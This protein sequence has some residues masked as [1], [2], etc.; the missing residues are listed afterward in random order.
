MKS[1]SI[2]GNRLSVDGSDT[3]WVFEI[4]KLTVP[5]VFPASIIAIFLHF[6]SK[7]SDSKFADAAKASETRFADAAKAS[8][9]KFAELLASYRDALVSDTKL[10]DEK[11]NASTKLFD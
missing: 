3:N 9:S 7:A 6:S 10:F 11:L 8:D 4:V 1:K 5:T 2:R